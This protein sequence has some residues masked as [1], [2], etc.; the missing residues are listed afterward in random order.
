MISKGKELRIKTCGVAHQRKFACPTEKIPLGKRIIP[1]SIHFVKGQ[2]ILISCRIP[3]THSRP[4]PPHTTHS[5]K[6]S[7]KM[8]HF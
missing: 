5:C 1:F 8:I 2:T 4:L 6:V 7:T 3:Q